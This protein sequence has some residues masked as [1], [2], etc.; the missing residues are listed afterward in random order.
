MT[1]GQD[2]V[3]E[4]SRRNFIHH[5]SIHILAY[6]QSPCAVTLGRSNL[7]DVGATAVA[8]TTQPV[9]ATVAPLVHEQL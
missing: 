8:V 3:V 5:L 4:T 6:T 7:N 2:A 1:G 9:L